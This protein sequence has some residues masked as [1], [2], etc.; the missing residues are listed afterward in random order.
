MRVISE[1]ACLH[2]GCQPCNFIYFLDEETQTAFFIPWNTYFG[3]TGHLILQELDACFQTE[4]SPRA[5]FAEASVIIAMIG[6]LTE[7]V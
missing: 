3:G 7:S 6:M 5:T 1:C 4:S 2:H